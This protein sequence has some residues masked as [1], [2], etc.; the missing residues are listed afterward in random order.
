MTEPRA[1]VVV[2]GAAGMLGRAFREL[3]SA[4]GTQH[5]AVDLPE[6]DL[7]DASS[8]ARHVAPGARTVINCAAFTDVDGAEQREADATRDNGEGVRVLAERCA[9][10]GA[11]LLHFSTDYVF[12]GR[13]TS[14]YRVDQPRAPLNAY[15]RSKAVG[16]ELLE[17]SGASALLVRTSWLYASWGKNF[18]LTMREL[19]RT[20]RHV[21]VV[22]DQLGRPTSSSYLAERSLALLERGCRGAFHVTDGGQCSWYELA[23]RVKDVTGSTCDVEPCSTAEFPRPA[24]RPGYSVLDLSATE[25][26]L[27]PSKP[28]QEN[29]AT[30]LSLAGAGRP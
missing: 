3:L 1:E 12:D 30:A 28:W 9:S 4:R 16:E 26:L 18:V 14:P 20:R 19:M 23:C 13:A 27:G 25:A 24:A 10:V 11:A 6:L 21:K 22:E 2:V 7:C 17:R 29:V 8:V 15:G 5:L